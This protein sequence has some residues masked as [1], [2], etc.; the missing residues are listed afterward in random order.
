MIN[1]GTYLGQKKCFLN[2]EIHNTIIVDK[3][4]SY[5]LY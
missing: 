4:D 1:E 3:V 5:F 2:Q